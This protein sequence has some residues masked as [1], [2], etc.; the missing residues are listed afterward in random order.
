[1]QKITPY[2]AACVIL[3]LA[4]S[5]AYPMGGGPTNPEASPYAILEPQTVGQPMA[6]ESRPVVVDTAQSRHCPGDRPCRWANHRRHG[7]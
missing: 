3:T 2:G 4:A 5:S 1:M 6:A 7:S